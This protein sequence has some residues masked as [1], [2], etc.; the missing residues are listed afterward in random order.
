MLSLVFQQQTAAGGPA[1]LSPEVEAQVEA[2][3][4][5]DFNELDTIPIATMEVGLGLRSG[6]CPSALGAVALHV[7]AA[8]AAKQPSTFG[9]RASAA[10]TSLSTGLL[11]RCCAL[12]HKHRRSGAGGGGRLRRP[13]CPG[14]PAGHAALPGAQHEH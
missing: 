2:V 6:H 11:P 8:A 9:S 3:S 7:A 5:L 14:D 10:S 13:W 1:R 4:S 12:K